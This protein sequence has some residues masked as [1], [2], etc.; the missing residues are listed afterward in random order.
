VKNATCGTLLGWIVVSLLLSSCTKPDSVPTPAAPAIPDETYEEFLKRIGGEAKLF[1]PLEREVTVGLLGVSKTHE[2]QL[3]R[4]VAARETAKKMNVR[5]L[6][7]HYESDVTIQ[8]RKA[9]E[10]V[11]RGAEALVST[12]R[13]AE[14]FDALAKFLNRQNV[15]LVA[16]GGTNEGFTRQSAPNYVAY[17]GVDN[18][19]NGHEG[20]CWAAEYFQK[21]YPDKQPRLVVANYPQV[22]TSAERAKGFID[23]FKSVLPELVLEFDAAMGKGTG[24]DEVLPFIEDLFT[25]HQFNIFF[26]VWD[27]AAI[28]GWT[29]ARARGLTNK[30]LMIV[31]YDGTREVAEYIL[32]SDSLFVADIG[33]APEL[34]GQVAVALAAKVVAGELRLEDIPLHIYVP[35]VLITQE[36]AQQFLEATGGE[37]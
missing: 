13:D 9:E 22:H 6:L 11:V 35:G 8:R 20:G 1:A 26:A 36:T 19:R 23:G 17:V 5:L 10:M 32:E 34:S 37:N 28:A 2:Y 15:Y 25:A 24:R 16:E 29:A 3:R 21:T 14:S 4:D 33:Q 27:E 31:G 7:D 18:Y 30:D 12:A